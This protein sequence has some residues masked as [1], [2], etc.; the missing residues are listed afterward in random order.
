VRHVP[1]N[2]Y[3]IKVASRCNLDCL[4]C[5]EYNMGDD[6]WRSMPRLMA[7]DVVALVASRIREHCDAH[8]LREVYVNLHGGEP[9]LYGKRNT[10]HL[11]EVFTA[12][13]AGVR[14]HWGVQTNGILLDEE[15]VELLG[16][17]NF[18]LGLSLDGPAQ[19][20]D[21]LRVDHRGR[22]SHQRVMEGVRHL[23]SGRGERIFAGCLTVIDPRSEPLEVFHHLLELGAKSIDFLLPH[24]NWDDPPPSKKGDPMTGTP[25]ADWLIPVF[26]E[27]FDRYSGVVQVRT[28]EEIIEHLAGGPGRLE[29]VGLQPVSLIGVAVDGSIEGVDTLKSIPGQQVLGLHLSAHSFDDAMRHPKYMLRQAGVESL[30]PTCQS[31]ELVTTCGGGYLPHRWSKENQFRNPSVFCADLTSLIRHIRVRVC[32]A[33]KV[34]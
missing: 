4:Y 22:G 21:R 6:S 23:R 28:F 1:I 2:S 31:C 30:S 33:L 25:Y 32:S 14:I 16:G 12:V 9:L 15:W 13:L 20:N 10:R 11:L 3:I 17:Y 24:G 26:D 27:W 34:I 7:S 18:H 19:V 29:T 5:Y 8:G